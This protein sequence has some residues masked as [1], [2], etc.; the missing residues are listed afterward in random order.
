MNTATD[1]YGRF[2]L[3]RDTLI[4]ILDRTATACLRIEQKSLA[5]HLAALRDKAQSNRFKV[6]VVGT[7]KNGKSTFI[8]ALLGERVLPAYAVPCTAVI[9]EVKWGSEKSATLHFRDPLPKPLPDKLSPKA[10]AH[11]QKANGR[12]PEPLTIPVTELED[13]VVIAD[14]ARPQQD[15]VAETPYERAEVF[16]P[17]ELCRNGV[18][19][20]DSPGLNE[21]GTR[22]KVTVDYISQADAVLFVMSSLALASQTEINFVQ[23]NLHES[24]HRDIF[25]VCNRFDQLDTPREQ[26][27]V[28]V[29][30]L[31]RLS[32]L[33]DLR[34]D[35][36][37]FISAKQAMDGRVNARPEL[38]ETSG[39]LPLEKALSDFLVNQRG[40]I[41][42]LTPAREL[43]HSLRQLR[44][45][46]LPGQRKLLGMELADVERKVREI[47]P[48]LD[49]AR[50]AK[51]QLGKAMSQ[52]FEK[53]HA[54]VREAATRFVIELAEALP[55]IVEGSET[56]TQIKIFTIGHK[57]Q[58]EAL[59]KEVLEKVDLAVQQRVATWKTE[60]LDP[61]FRRS[62][63]DMQ[64]QIEHDITAFY[65]RLEGIQADIFDHEKVAI[66]SEE[67][68]SGSERFFAS[69]AGLLM[70]DIA[71]GV[72]GAQ[73][74]FKGLMSAIAV[75]FGVLIA[76][77]LIGIANPF[78][79]IAAMFGA[80][81]FNAVL[82]VGS[83]NDKV[84][85]QLAKE[86]QAAFKTTMH[87]TVATI[88]GKTRDVTGKI[89]DAAVQT[90]EGDIQTI[91][92]QADAA[93][94]DKQA[95]QQQVDAKRTA[96]DQVE[97]EL[98]AVSDALQNF[99]LE[100]ADSG[101]TLPAKT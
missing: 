6:M 1:A 96:L 31:D 51:E 97:L 5:Q 9:N 90:L 95:G 14:P 64:E 98:N 68:P 57:E 25:F 94:R 33:T 81:F 41:K 61:K 21:A 83:M 56:L 59:V 24:G 37:H 16:W 50:R 19:I 42:L 65:E 17:L 53:L 60:V 26:E 77:G 15:S 10:V 40:R 70:G 88:T 91:Q 55:G 13:F 44:Q 80:G 99:I 45:E 47:T 75:Q 54:D 29:H 93:L 89:C 52:H 74:G 32:A 73:F 78:V 34:S 2:N 84:K 18:E 82:R 20:I 4:E 92:E 72:Y 58:I 67:T 100:L 39:I 87:E 38:L 76:L 79:I 86:V 36:V 85:K 3:R 27:R 22:E 23:F 43:T 28:R 30:A 12:T 7:F 62:V 11:I 48:M 46:I 69:V 101:R 49:D 8:N 35:G 63:E 66:K 71:T